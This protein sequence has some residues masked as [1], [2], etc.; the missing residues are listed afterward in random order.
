MLNLHSRAWYFFR[1]NVALSIQNFPKCFS[2]PY[3]FLKLLETSIKYE[4][5]IRQFSPPQ[6]NSSGIL[7]TSRLV[8]MKDFVLHTAE[9]VPF[10]ISRNGNPEH[11]KFS[12]KKIELYIKCYSTAEISMEVPLALD[13]QF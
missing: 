10:N 12:L 1:I 6:K 13:G 7:Y 4:G 11:L 8:S 9:N 2:G 5:S 3:R